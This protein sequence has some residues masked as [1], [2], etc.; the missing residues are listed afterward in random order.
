MGAGMRAALLSFMLAMLGACGGGGGGGGGTVVVPGPSAIEVPLSSFAAIAPNQ[1]VVMQGT[2]VTLTGSSTTS[3]GITTV[4]SANASPIDNATV[5]FSYDSARTLS[6]ITIHTPQGSFTFDRI[7][8]D[9]TGVCSGK[10][11]CRAENATMAVV[12]VDPVIAGWNYQSLG[13]WGTDF[14]PAAWTFGAISAGSPTSG[15]A[16]PTTGSA[17][18][19]GLAVGMY[20]DAAGTPYATSA[21]MSANANFGSR[22]IQFSTSE[23]T[24]TKNK[25][26]TLNNN[27]NLS[28]TLTYAPGVNSFSGSLQTSNSQLNGQGAGRFYGPGA[29]EMGGVYSLSDGGVNRM[30]GGFGA[31]R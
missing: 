17:V 24:L 6:A 18:F 30:F 9:Q 10:G 29:E 15:P 5:K 3:G 31:K 7:A 19:N 25:V 13:I 4:T 1:T 8:P 14:G 22:S 23:T 2:S 11:S 27:L 12:A 28:G 20:F 16:V 21:K 26:D